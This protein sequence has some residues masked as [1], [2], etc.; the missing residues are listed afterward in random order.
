[1]FPQLVICFVLHC[2][3]NSAVSSGVQSLLWCEVCYRNL[4]T[5]TF[6]RS[7]LLRP[8]S[9]L[10]LS[11]PPTSFTPSFLLR[12][13]PPFSSI[14]LRLFLRRDRTCWTLPYFLVITIPCDFRQY[15][16]ASGPAK[17]NPTG[18]CSPTL[19]ALQ[20]PKG[21][22]VLRPKLLLRQRPGRS[23]KPHNA[24]QACQ[25][26]SRLPRTRN[27]DTLPPRHLQR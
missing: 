1:M 8:S 2:D 6:H 7:F 13:P 5:V 17:H 27:A 15:G 20:S 18:Y 23:Q 12:F 22:Y 25:D 4:Q 24:G 10:L 3:Q 16:L 26:L 19:P 14:V 9:L 11:P 21:T